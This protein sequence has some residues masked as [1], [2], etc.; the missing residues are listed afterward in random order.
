MKSAGA[1]D[2]VI[3]A[4]GKYLL[5]GAIDDQVHFREPGLTHKG[6]IYTESK[7][8]V[9]G[10]VTSFMEMPNTNPPAVTMELL[11]EKF[12]T[13]SQ[14]SMANFSF[15]LGATNNNI[16]EILRADPAKVCGI[17]VF[18]GSSTG[19][20]L[21]DDEA[22]LRKI[23]EKSPMLVATH[24]EDEQTIRNNLQAF[25]DKYGQDIPAEAHPQIRSAEACY[26]SSSFAVE[27]AREFNTRLHVLHI[28]TARELGLFENKTALKEKRITAEACI[29]HLWFS[30]K[31]Y[32]EKGNLIKWNPAVKTDE[33]RKA[34]FAGILDGRI[35]V[36][37]TD[38][39]PHPLE[40]K[41]RKYQDAPSGGPMVQHSLL[42]MLELYHRGKIRIEK[43]V[44][45]MSHN[46]AILYHVNRRGFIREGFFADLV[47]VDLMRP[48]RVSKA[49]LLYKCGWSP[50]E[51]I[52]FSSQIV[53][54]LVN[55]HLVYQDGKFDES[56]RGMALQF[57]R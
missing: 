56:K 22:A 21:V 41:Q 7:A 36:V 55:G 53:A 19:N 52:D 5:P 6:D 16:E 43:I 57:D 38:H 4:K 34:I 14:K 32:S 28:S 47:L 12:E 33:D 49:N 10:G 1:G 48:Y 18:M 46:P 8:A 9:A 23:F 45:L 42:A 31:D 50:M 29:H 51:G 3:E 13:G 37:A 44:E 27:L 26:K 17:K 39:A 24:C 2:R 15:Y 11:Y 35:D 25:R 30:D 40:E 54:T 20:M